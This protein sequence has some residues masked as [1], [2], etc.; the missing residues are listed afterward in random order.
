[1]HENVSPIK[2]WVI[3]QRVMLVFGGVD[4]EMQFS[5]I[6]EIYIMT[7]DMF[8]PSMFMQSRLS[9]SRKSMFHP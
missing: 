8:F 5:N 1:M 3:F 4:S 2:N 9:I 6:L 7:H